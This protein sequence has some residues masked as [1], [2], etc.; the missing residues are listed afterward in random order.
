MSAVA[1]KATQHVA[2]KWAIYSSVEHTVALAL[3]KAGE[4]ELI[5]PIPEVFGVNDAGNSVRCLIHIPGEKLSKVHRALAAAYLASPVELTMQRWPVYYPVEEA[6]AREL[7][8]T[9]DIEATLPPD[10][11]EMFRTDQE[12]RPVL[13][14]LTIPADKL[15]KFHRAFADAYSR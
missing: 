3:A 2:Q 11:P 14:L 6:A 15:A 5:S 7:A 12:G 13:C 8:Q 4:V 1:G 10:I 9:D